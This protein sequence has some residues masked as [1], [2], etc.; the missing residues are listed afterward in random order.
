[1]KITG[2]NE[3]EY[4]H[5]ICRWTEPNIASLKILVE[6]NLVSIIKK[7]RA[8]INKQYCDAKW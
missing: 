2:I 5:V 3:V 1:M 7:P 4:I 6:T 8:F